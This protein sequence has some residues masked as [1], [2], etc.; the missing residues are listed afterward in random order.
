MFYYQTSNISASEGGA[1]MGLR[2]QQQPESAASEGERV[3]LALPCTGLAR[4]GAG[5]G[6][7]FYERSEGRKIR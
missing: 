7:A 1:L 3:Q 2:E 5:A 4:E 6:F